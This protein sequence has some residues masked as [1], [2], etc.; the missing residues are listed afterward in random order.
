M[1]DFYP[2]GRVL[3]NNSPSV[4]V[5]LQVNVSSSDGFGGLSSTA[6]LRILP[7]SLYALIFSD[8]SMI[9]RAIVP[10]YLCSCVRWLSGELGSV[11]QG[12]S[13]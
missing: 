10:Q 7:L 12:F 9:V 8:D 5:V 2:A 11:H 4:C 1:P 3:I 6:I 13:F